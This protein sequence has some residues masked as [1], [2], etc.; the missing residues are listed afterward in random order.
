[1]WLTLGAQRSSMFAADSAAMARAASQDCGAC[2]V[3]MVDAGAC[4]VARQKQ[5]QQPEYQVRSGESQCLNCLR[6]CITIISIKLFGGHM[7]CMA[8][9]NERAFHVWCWLSSLC[10]ESGRAHMLLLCV[11]CR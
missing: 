9:C 5:L 1:M 11:C 3:V 4:D 2:D 8:A 10:G 6:C 7:S